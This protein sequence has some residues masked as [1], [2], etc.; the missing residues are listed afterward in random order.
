MLKYNLIKK[1][2]SSDD[3]GDTIGE[4][5]EFLLL[6]KC[7]S[8]IAFSESLLDPDVGNIVTSLATALSYPHKD[9]SIFY[10]L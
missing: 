4:S 10:Y 7:F 1:L 2:T 8:T 3:D 6:K 5:L 9:A